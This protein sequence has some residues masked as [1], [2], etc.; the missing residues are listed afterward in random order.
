VQGG[1]EDGICVTAPEVGLRGDQVLDLGGASCRVQIEVGPGGDLALLRA[2]TEEVDDVGPAA[3][4][5]A[6]VD[7][8]A[9]DLVV[10]VRK[11]APPSPRARR[12]AP[13]LRAA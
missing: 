5:V 4:G 11:E 2:G 10:D 3:A 6:S 9:Y 1:G 13:G 7:E 8:V 12:P